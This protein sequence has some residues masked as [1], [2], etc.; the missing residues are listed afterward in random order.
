MYVKCALDG[1]TPQYFHNISLKIYGEN[2]KAVSEMKWWSPR[3]ASFNTFRARV[4]FYLSEP[5]DGAA[6]AFFWNKI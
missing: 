4:K 3:L 1:F 5:R 6:E 2:Q